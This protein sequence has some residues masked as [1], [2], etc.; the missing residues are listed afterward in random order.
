M[1]KVLKEQIQDSQKEM[2]PSEVKKVSLRMEAL[3]KL[4][5]GASQAAS[6]LFREQ[7]IDPSAPDFDKEAFL[8]QVQQELNQ[9]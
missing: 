5:P 8:K 2:S 9:G 6:R 3:Q 7:Q 1:D 4:G